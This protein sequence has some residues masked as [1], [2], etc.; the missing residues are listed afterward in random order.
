MNGFPRY[1]AIMLAFCFS[2]TAQSAANPNGQASRTATVP[3]IEIERKFV[4]G[5]FGQ[6][7]I[8]VANPAGESARTPLVLFHPTPY[9]GDYFTAF[10]KNMSNDRQVIAIDTPGYGD[11]DAPD[12]L[13]TIRD[14]AESAAAVLDSLGFR[15]GDD[16]QID[17]LGYHTGSLIAAELALI[18]PQ[19][20]RRIVLPGLPFFTGDRRKAA[21]DRNAK[22]DEIAQDGSHLI[23]KW[24]FSTGATSVGLSLARGQ[25]HFNDAV[26]CYPDCWKAYHAVFTYESDK[27]LVKITQP[28]LL[29]TNAGSLKE[30]TEAA[31]KYLRRAELVDFP[32]ITLGGFDLHTEALADAVRGFLDDGS[33]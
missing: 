33:K 26:Q 12:S 20:V 11:S 13:P 14:Y 29:M 32:E 16:L 17:V 15:P 18:R 6:V 24:K 7:H 3:V 4:Q 31:Q 5:P 23:E 9:S 10:M 25:E 2:S 1:A 22:P 27:Q 21:Y 30:E 8:R 28:V 19:L